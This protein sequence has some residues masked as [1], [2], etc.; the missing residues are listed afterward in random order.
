M[1]SDAE[2]IQDAILLDKRESIVSM[3]SVTY[4]EPNKSFTCTLVLTTK[5]FFLV[6]VRGLFS[7]SVAIL[8]SVPYEDVVRI[9]LEPQMLFWKK[10]VFSINEGHSTSDFSFLNVPDVEMVYKRIRELVQQAKDEK[11]LD[12]TVVIR[13][14]KDEKPI[15]MLKR[16]LARGEITTKEFHE[17]VQRI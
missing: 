5:R 4:S 3:L 16:K 12:A 8:K 1:S 10:I 13:Q 9:T 6:Q 7:K 17:R 11:T 14:K 2:L 15:E